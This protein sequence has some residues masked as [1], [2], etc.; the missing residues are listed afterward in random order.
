MGNISP[1]YSL[2]G[3]VI[4]GKRI[5]P[6]TSLPPSQVSSATVHHGGILYHCMSGGGT[7]TAYKPK[8]D[9]E[10]LCFS[11]LVRQFGD[12]RTVARKIRSVQ[13]T[14][15]KPSRPGRQEANPVVKVA[16]DRDGRMGVM[17]PG[18]RCPLAMR[19]ST[20]IPNPF[21]CMIQYEKNFSFR[22]HL[23]CPVVP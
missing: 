9:V 16:R 11:V 12:L 1:L 22:V 4:Q 5:V 21:N 15:K 8:C 23:E 14:P 19:F 6:S 10:R 7:S 20:F 18:I 3:F 17:E 13:S 2:L